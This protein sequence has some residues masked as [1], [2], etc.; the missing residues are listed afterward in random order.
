MTKRDTITG[1]VCP[2]RKC[3]VDGV[4][5]NPKPVIKLHLFF[6]NPT[7]RCKLLLFEERKVF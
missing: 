5:L 6:L 2:N 3:Q 4:V 7:P 1:E